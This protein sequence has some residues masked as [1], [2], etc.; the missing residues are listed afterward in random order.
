MRQ[1]SE[2]GQARDGDRDEHQADDSTR[3]EDSG[4]LDDTASALFVG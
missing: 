4:G 1:E 3:S 2:V